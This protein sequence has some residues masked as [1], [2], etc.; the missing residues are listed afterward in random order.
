MGDARQQ[1]TIAIGKLNDLN[2]LINLNTRNDWFGLNWQRG[3]G[4]EFKTVKNMNM[5]EQKEVW[6]DRRTPNK[7]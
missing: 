2:D 4:A 3:S 5:D 7:K 6:T 1:R